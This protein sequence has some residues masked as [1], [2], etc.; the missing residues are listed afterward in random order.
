M[1][2]ITVFTEGAQRTLT[3]HRESTMNAHKTITVAALNLSFNVS[4]ERN[5]VMKYG[6]MPWHDAQRERG[7]G[8]EWFLTGQNPWREVEHYLANNTDAEIA[9]DMSATGWVWSPETDSDDITKAIADERENALD[10][11]EDERAEESDD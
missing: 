7:E 4:T 8:V 9:R 2:A 1:Y 5:D 10:W 3:T 6:A 11:I